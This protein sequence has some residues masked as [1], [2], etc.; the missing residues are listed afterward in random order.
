MAKLF[1]SFVNVKTGEI[2]PVEPSKFT[3]SIEYK[4]QGFVCDF[5]TYKA[6]NKDSLPWDVIEPVIN[7]GFTWQGDYYGSLEILIKLDKD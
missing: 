6:K 7:S 2:L 4:D 1:I 3:P 5:D